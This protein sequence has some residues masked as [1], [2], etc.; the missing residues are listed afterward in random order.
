MNKAQ[1]Y[2][3]QVWEQTQP[4]VQ[5]QIQSAPRYQQQEPVKQVPV[6]ETPV[7]QAPMNTTTPT[8]RK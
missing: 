5:P 1:E 8:R 4:I 6:K 3:K 7:K 2:H